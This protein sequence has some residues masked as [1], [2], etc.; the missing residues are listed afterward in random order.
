M[1]TFV[2]VCL[3][4]GMLLM[5]PG[6]ASADLTDGLVG[7]WSFDNCDAIDDSGN[8]N[9]GTLMKDPT[10]VT[11][12][13]SMGFD[14][15]GY[16]TQAWRDT[17]YIRV[18]NSASLE[19]AANF[20]WNVWFKIEDYLSMDGWGK[21]TQYGTQAIL[22]KSGDR[23]SLVLRVDRNTSDDKLYAYA[24]N[25]KITGTWKQMDVPEGFG[26]NEWHMLTVTHPEFGPG[27]VKL[28][29]DG[30]LVNSMPAN[31]FL[32]N[33]Q[34]KYKP[35]FMGMGQWGYYYPF[36]GVLDEVRIYNRVL[37]D[38]E[39]QQLYASAFD[40][41]GDGVPDGDDLCPGTPSEVIVDE[42]GCSIA[43]L[44]P[45]DSDWGNHG[46][47][48]SCAAQAAE[49]FLEKGLITESDKDGIVSDAA[50]SACGKKARGK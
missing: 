40:A 32:M 50:K 41:D 39:I 13:Q 18:P 8:G 26:L 28:Y 33:Q 31:E 11:G 17:D 35:V 4:L 49:S 12:V 16:N 6:R 5:I 47:Y 48:V 45:C 42:G 19:F 1:K 34:M 20:S 2:T 15:S 30:V 23:E 3:S 43:Q 27:L 10:C 14:L 46:K 7:Y 24:G 21:P 9:T 25:G 29:F 36:N 38:S 37:T 22:T 44:C